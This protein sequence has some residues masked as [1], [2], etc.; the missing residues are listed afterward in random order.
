MDNT[1]HALCGGPAGVE[2]VDFTP[3]TVGGLEVAVGT[4]GASIADAGA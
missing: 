3:T 2:W 4:D 1:R